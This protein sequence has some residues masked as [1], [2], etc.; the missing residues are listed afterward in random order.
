MVYKIT[1]SDGTVFNVKERDLPLI[2][3]YLLLEGYPPIS[4]ELLSDLNHAEALQE[5]DI[6]GS[7]RSCHL[8]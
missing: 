1:T 8:D 5:L 7:L 3:A 4:V 6:A 2:T